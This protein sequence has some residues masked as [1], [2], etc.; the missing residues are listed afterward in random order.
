MTLQDKRISC[1]V[2]S[3]PKISV[4]LPSYNHAKYIKKSIESVLSQH[5]EDFELLISDDAS[6]DNSWDV[7]SSINDKRIFAFLQDQN[8]GPVGNLAFLVGKARGKYIALIN[9]DDFWEPEKLL[10][11]IFIMDSMPE[12]GACF[13][14]ASLVD[15]HGSEVTG[16]ESI[17][18][19]IFRQ[20]NRTQGKWLRHFFNSGNC[21]CHPSMLMRKEVYEAIGFYNPAFKQLPDFEMWIRLVKSYPIHIIQENLVAHLRTGNNTSVVSQENIARNVNELVEIFGT[22]F[23]DMPDEIFIDGFSDNFR[24]Q[25]ASSSILRHECEKLFLLLDHTFLLPAGKMAAISLLFRLLKKYE[26]EKILREEYHF[27]VFDFYRISG[28]AGF[29][30][31][32]L[33]SIKS[34]LQ[35]EDYSHRKS[36]TRKKIWNKFLL[37]KNLIKL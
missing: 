31:L 4:I 32:F 11:Q 20:P 30:G 6:L 2:L 34:D 13:T 23:E 27:S 14:W 7:I 3:A 16:S 15:D 18:R 35:T 26:I 1:D 28:V 9:S 25:N 22:F 24:N 29:G 37:C 8:L 21:L 5:F 17:W 33:E 10:K 36:S 19:D 12:L